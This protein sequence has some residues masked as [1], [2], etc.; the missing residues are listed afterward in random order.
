MLP[1][2]VDCQLLKNKKL[3]TQH[4]KLKRTT[5]RTTPPPKKKTPN[6]TKNKQ[7]KKQEIC[8]GQQDKSSTFLSSPK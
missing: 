1:V 5:T 6:K 3:K 2:E 4:R 8:D 7:T